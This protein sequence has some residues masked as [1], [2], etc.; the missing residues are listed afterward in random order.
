MAGEHRRSQNVLQPG[1][2]VVELGGRVRGEP[3]ARFARRE[4]EH[5]GDQQALH[6][7]HVVLGQP[8]LTQGRVD[9]VAC[10]GPPG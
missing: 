7:H 6:L 9:D 3:P 4:T 8:R 2:V 10:G 1:E 5:R